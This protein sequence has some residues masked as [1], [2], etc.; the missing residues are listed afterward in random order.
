MKTCPHCT[1]ENDLSFHFCDRCGESFL[2]RPARVLWPR[3]EALERVSNG[4]RFLSRLAGLA[5][6]LGAVGVLVHFWPQ[7]F[8]VA[9]FFAG[10]AAL[11]GY[12][13][14][15]LLRALAEF[16]RLLLD[17]EDHLR[18]LRSPLERK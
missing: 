6:A 8:L 15:V 16:V 3:Y 2:E 13:A 14:L 1:A 7:S 11:A 12:L 17:V 10:A 18:T 4:V 5:G 9:V